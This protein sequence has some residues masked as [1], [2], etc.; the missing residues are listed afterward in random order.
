MSEGNLNSTWEFYYSEYLDTERR[1]RE[2]KKEL[3]V[4]EVL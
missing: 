1:K 4:L 2:E 3:E